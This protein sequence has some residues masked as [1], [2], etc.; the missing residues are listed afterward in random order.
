[1]S[2]FA[3][4]HAVS[5]SGNSDQAYLLNSHRRIVARV[6]TGQQGTDLDLRLAGGQSREVSTPV[7]GMK[8][9][10]GDAV[11]TL[12]GGSYRLIVTYSLI[13]GDAPIGTLVSSPTDFTLIK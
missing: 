11:T 2:T 12:P 13:D 10:G 7:V 9:C 6:P 4:S 1:M 5:L 8:T 3:A